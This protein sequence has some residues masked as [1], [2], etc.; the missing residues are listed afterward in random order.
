MQYLQTLFGPNSITKLA[1]KRNQDL[2]RVIALQMDADVVAEYLNIM[3][4][5][6][7]TPGIQEHFGEDN[8]S[9]KDEHRIEA[10]RSF[11]MGQIA[12]APSIFRHCLKASHISQCLTSI[13]PIAFAGSEM[14][15]TLRI[16]SQFKLFSM[17]ETL[18][19]IKF[20]DKDVAKKGFVEGTEKLW[21]SVANAKIHNLIKKDE[22]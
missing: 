7:Q 22:E 13:I 15:Q 8:D 18:Q 16:G 20:G 19:K 9:N 1:V 12:A 2:L 3:H 5:Q 17:V 10:I 21:L 4:G 6:I 11:S 14:K